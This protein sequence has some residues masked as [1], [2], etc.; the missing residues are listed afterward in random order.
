MATLHASRWRL[1]LT[2]RAPAGLTHGHH[3]LVLTPTG[4][5]EGA[6]GAGHDGRVDLAAVVHHLRRKEA[7]QFGSHPGSETDPRAGHRPTLTSKRQN[8]TSARSRP[9]TTNP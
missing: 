2:S 6:G 8:T 9:L 4:A 1:A 7:L 3:V 5:A